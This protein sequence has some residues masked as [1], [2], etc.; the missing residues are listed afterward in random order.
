[1]IYRVESSVLKKLEALRWENRVLVIHEPVLTAEEGKARVESLK[2]AKEDLEERDLA[3]LK[4]DAEMKK[5]YQVKEDTFV[6]LLFGK[7]GGLKLRQEGK[8]DL[9][10][11]YE[12][13]DQMPMRQ[14][15]MR[16]R[17]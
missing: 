8:M 13:I 10:A 15:E 1:M 17:E 16:G 12:L 2:K 14:R 7:D 11:L 3:I 9:E 6:L 4:M 5:K